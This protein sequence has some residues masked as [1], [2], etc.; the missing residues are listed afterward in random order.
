MR[1]ARYN[2]LSQTVE[3]IKT[4]QVT[5]TP[6]KTDEQQISIGG[7]LVIPQ[8]LPDGNYSGELVLTFVY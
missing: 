2:T 5:S 3:S 6:T 4:N 7:E 8:N 1:K